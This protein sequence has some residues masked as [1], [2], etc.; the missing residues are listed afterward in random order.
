MMAD[1]ISLDQIRTDESFNL[2]SLNDED[3]NDM[4]SPDAP[5]KYEHKTACTMNQMY[6]Q[7]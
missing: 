6:F 1:N 4:E 7:D 3:N 5:F 2:L